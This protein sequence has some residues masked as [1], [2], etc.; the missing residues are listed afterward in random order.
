MINDAPRAATI[1]TCEN[2]AFAVIDKEA[3]MKV[4]LKIELK[5]KA[6]INAFLSSVP[7]FKGW[8]RKQMQNLYLL[9]EERHFTY[10]QT[11]YHENLPTE[12]VYIIK[13]GEFELVKTRE[14][15]TQQSIKYDEFI[16]PSVSRDDLIPGNGNVVKSSC[17][18]TS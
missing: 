9:F 5:A 11:V 7:I 13:E 18:A 12:Y 2:S 17:L 4:L 10:N 16:G 3:Y 6:K 15:E 14:Q 8:N 1:E